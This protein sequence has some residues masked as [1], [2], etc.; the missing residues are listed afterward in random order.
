MLLIR[1]IFIVLARRNQIETAI[2]GCN[3]TLSVSVV[4]VSLK[5]YVFT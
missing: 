1:R 4:L 5:L 3:P 2:H